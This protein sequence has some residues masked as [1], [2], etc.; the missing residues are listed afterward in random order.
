MEIL[1]DSKSEQRI[2]CQCGGHYQNTASDKQQHENT[3]I[4]IKYHETKFKSE[5]MRERLKK[6]VG[7]RIRITYYTTNG[8]KI[9]ISGDVWWIYK[10]NVSLSRNSGNYKID[11]TRIVDFVEE[12]Y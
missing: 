2:N 1:E 4:H 12:K 9:S 3:K 11:L 5:Q 6:Y 7:S 10:K 8:R